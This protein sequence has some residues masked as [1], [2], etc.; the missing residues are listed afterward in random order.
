[1]NTKLKKFLSTTLIAS[2]LAFGNIQPTMAAA[3]T[4]L[5]WTND[6]NNP[7]PGVGNVVNGWQEPTTGNW[8]CTYWGVGVCNAQA[9]YDGEEHGNALR[10]TH[11]GSGEGFAAWTLPS[12]TSGKLLFQFDIKM[13]SGSSGVTLAANSLPN[14]GT[15]NPVLGI[16]SNQVKLE[17]DTSYIGTYEYNK[18]NTV[19]LLFDIDKGELTG[20]YNGN[21]SKT[22]K[23]YDTSMKFILNS[24]VD[25][26]LDNLHAEMIDTSKSVTAEYVAND[27]EIEKYAD[28]DTEEITVGIDGIE[29]ASLP[30]NIT[31]TDLGDDR[32]SSIDDDEVEIT[33]K[34]TADGKIS[35]ALD[36]YLDSGRIY[37]L[38]IGNAKDIFGR[39]VS[40]KEITFI[41][42]G[43]NGWKK[44]AS[45]SEDFSSGTV[46]DFFK[47]NSDTFQIVS[48]DS[49]DGGKALEFSGEARVKMN[50]APANQN[51][52]KINIKMKI[53]SGN[54]AKWS[55][56][57]TGNDKVGDSVKL[58]WWYAD[59]NAYID[60]L[61]KET[62][63]WGW[64]KGVDHNLPRATGMNEIT[65][66]IDFDMQK[67]TYSVNGGTSYT[68]YTP[69]YSESGAMKNLNQGIET[70]VFLAPEA[71]SIAASGHMII[72]SFSWEQEYQA[73]TV[74]KIAFVDADGN[75]VEY[76][77]TTG[78]DLDT[79]IKLYFSDALKEDTLK[80][81]S[82]KS[83]NTAAV[84]NGTWNADDNSYTIAFTG[85]GLAQDTTYALTVPETVTDNSGFAAT[86]A[87]GTFKTAKAS[88]SV[89]SVEFVGIDS[90]ASYGS[91]KVTVK[92]T[93]KNTYPT[94]KNVAI[95]FAGYN[96]T[97]LKNATYNSVAVPAGAESVTTEFILDK[98]NITKIKAF[99]LTDI[100]SMQPYCAAAEK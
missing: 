41:A 76:D 32:I 18:W 97:T 25:I 77:E 64:T 6:F 31:L 68:N 38:N 29:F 21:T 70:F 37:K 61:Y 17:G 83:G 3:I 84:F 9:V 26:M 95:V 10:I 34:L 59:S 87:Y 13:M 23:S 62:F 74:D 66:S 60:C 8:Q 69:I 19:R 93:V 92:A 50:G 14:G 47:V 33:A 1:M 16:G 35:I 44:G 80:N 39:T 89:T 79:K 54:W 90:L 94:A 27:T 22:S 28:V 78:I 55:Y 51:R 11:T 43:N 52:G 48:G 88:L 57:T 81:I 98:T 15:W 91:N 36:D 75:E 85:D 58:I 86:S 100:G 45:K 49:Y 53:Q 96:G 71:Q 12:I 20:Y 42:D 30:N 40:N 56:L 24:G 2:V 46:G 65:Y 7:D 99:A 67:S 72:D 82:V 4:S 63:G 5:P 73:V